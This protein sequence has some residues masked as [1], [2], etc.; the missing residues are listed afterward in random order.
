MVLADK[1]VELGFAD[2]V[3]RHQRKQKQDESV[4][5]VIGMNF[6]FSMSAVKQAMPVMQNS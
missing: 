3:S 6:A 2:E 5:N 4:Q 1:A